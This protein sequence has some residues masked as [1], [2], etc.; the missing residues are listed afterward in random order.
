MRSVISV[1]RIRVI[2]VA[3]IKYA[4]SILCK[5]IF[6]I[7]YRNLKLKFN[8]LMQTLKR[9]LWYNFYVDMSVKMSKKCI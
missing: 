5:L 8:M 2:S 4:N 3:R 1:A 9:V 6:Y 7:I